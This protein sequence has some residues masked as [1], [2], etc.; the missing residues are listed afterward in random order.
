MS[1]GSR[2]K[3]EYVSFSEIP[4]ETTKG[5]IVLIRQILATLL[6]I[7]PYTSPLTV[8]ARIPSS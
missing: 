1:I 7:F 4:I 2:G 3:T 6:G 5:L 8:Q